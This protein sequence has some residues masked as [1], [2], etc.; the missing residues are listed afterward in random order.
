MLLAA[1]VIYPL[2]ALAFA[3]ISLYTLSVSFAEKRAVYEKNEQ[4]ELPVALRNNFLFPYAPAEL[5]CLLPDNDTG[6][7]LHKQIFVSV[8]PFKR[9]RIFVP[10]MHRYR[11]A[12]TAQIM[13]LTVYDPLKVIRLSRRL[14]ADT[15]LVILPRKLTLPELGF[16]FGGEQGSVPEQRRS[17][18]KDDLS[19]VR[20]YMTGDI[21]QLIHW[22]LSA[23]LDEMMV[24]Q[25]D[26]TGDRRS[27]LLCDLGHS[28]MTASAAIRQSDA[29]VEAA[30]AVAM[31]VSGTGVKL[32]ADTGAP[33]APVCEI[34]DERSF[35][36]FYE[37]MAVVPP[38]VEAMP[39]SELIGQYAAADMTAMFIVTAAVNESVFAAA[40]AAASRIDGAVVLL[41]VNCSGRKD[42]SD[43]DENSRFIFAEVSGEPAE[44]LPA[45]AEQIL[46]DHDRI[47]R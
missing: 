28:D 44:A 9:M 23:K 2:L 3:A 38:F 32:L 5:D 20:E 8:G 47:K 16:V 30:I 6:L 14:D 33:D 12:Y 22:K 24:K 27:V 36:R 4:F 46:A 39:L 31:S 25:Y 37:M 10:C 35:D 18:D 7:F 40:E 17:G 11:G 34:T 19:H 42:Y 15:E 41:Y 45:A 13:R 43:R 1:A 21:M 26:T 29:V